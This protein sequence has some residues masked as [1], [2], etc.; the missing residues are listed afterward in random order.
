MCFKIFDFKTFENPADGFL[1]TTNWRFFFSFKVHLLSKFTVFSLSLLV[2][3]D[4]IKKFV[5][6]VEEMFWNVND[7]RFRCFGGAI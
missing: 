1:P 5:F 2:K 4:G 6:C 3:R 7:L